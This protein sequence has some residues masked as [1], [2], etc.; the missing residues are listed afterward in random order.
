[1]ISNEFSSFFRSTCTKMLGKSWILNRILKIR[2]L[3]SLEFDGATKSVEKT[4]LATT[5]T[6]PAP[7]QLGGSLYPM[8]FSFE[9]KTSLYIKMYCF[10]LQ[11]HE[12]NQRSFVNIQ[13][14]LYFQNHLQQK[15]L[16]GFQWFFIPCKAEIVSSHEH[17]ESFNSG[18]ASLRYRSKHCACHH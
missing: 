5:E 7:L 11:I 15:L 18:D 9:K 4:M 8:G 16:D 14:T 6:S 17:L 10:F 1:M 12:Q 2:M 13:K 3:I